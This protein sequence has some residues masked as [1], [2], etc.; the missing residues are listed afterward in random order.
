MAKLQKFE[1]R[2]VY[3]GFRTKGLEGVRCRRARGD[4]KDE[5]Y[6]ALVVNWSGESSQRASG[7]LIMPF[8]D[9]PEWRQLGGHDHALYTSLRDYGALSKGY[10]DPIVMRDLRYKTLVNYG[11]DDDR[12]EAEKALKV[13]KRDAQETFLEVLSLFSKKYGQ[14]IGDRDLQY[15]TRK[16][17]HNL[18]AEDV[19]EVYKL[20]RR[21]SAAVGEL[22]H[23]DGDVLARRVEF[24]SE[25]A[26][27]VCSLIALDSSRDVGYLSRQL[28]SLE[29]LI[30]ELKEFADSTNDETAGFVVKIAENAEHF[31][32]FALAKAEQIREL[33]LDNRAYVIEERFKGMKEEMAAN[34]LYISYALDGWDTHATGWEAAKA[35]G[36]DKCEDFIL[37]LYRTMPRPTKELTNPHARASYDMKHA[38]M[39]AGTVKVMHSWDDESMD[40]ELYSRVQ[41]GKKQKGEKPLKP[42][43]D[44]MVKKRKPAT[45]EIGGTPMPDAELDDVLNLLSGALAGDR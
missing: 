15:V 37:A 12:T 31:V 16:I 1:E 5:Y 36:S 3:V 4:Y 19:N 33:V 39:R 13:E 42:L 29:Q 27:P 45:E 41:Q 44:H 18:L 2:G 8:S 14:T 40:E 28:G 17:L 9:V 30:H 21:L 26:A 35:E 38:G 11:T 34:R 25:F 7:D 6:E 32:T 20:A 10:M 23:V 22:T 24:Y 43:P